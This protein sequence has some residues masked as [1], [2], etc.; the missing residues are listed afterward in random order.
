MHCP[1]GS[2]AVWPVATVL[3]RDFS[4]LSLIDKT[5]QTWWIHRYFTNMAISRAWIG[6][7]V[8]WVKPSEI[9]IPAR[10]NTTP[11]FS[12]LQI[13]KCNV[14]SSQILCKPRI[15]LIAK[16]HMESSHWDSCDESHFRANWTANTFDCIPGGELCVLLFGLIWDFSGLFPHE[17]PSSNMSTHPKQ[18]GGK[19]MKCL[20]GQP[21]AGASECSIS[22]AYHS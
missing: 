15:I 21:V 12:F 4:S 20:D 14:E 18:W 22:S 6:W 8:L 16:L 19:I 13:W 3:I 7:G 10:M 17:I 1:F 2:D 9:E 11:N 5:V